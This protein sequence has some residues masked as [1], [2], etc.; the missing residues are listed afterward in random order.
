M[1]DT[2]RRIRA[3]CSV[4][5][6]GYSSGPGGTAEDTWLYEHAGQESNAA[7]FEGIWRGCSTALM[8]R[9]NYEGFHSV[10]PG[11]TAD[12]A[13]DQRTRAL[14]T[15]LNEVDKA[16]VSTTLTE[17]PWENSRIFR[18]LPTAVDTLRSE[19]GTDVL[20]INSASVIQGLMREDLLD[21]LHLAVVPVVLGGGLRL[22]PD[23]V[24]T[25]WSLESSTTLS[26]G[27]VAVHYR[28]A[29]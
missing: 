12:P 23:G 24:S 22:L 5:I 14:G 11:I 9:T 17:T 1:T 3:Q 25:S 18:D 27:A 2:T 29:R 4:S 19:D 20:V 16:V 15:W 28:R 10:W 21:D 6:D 7:H 13:T 8:G 26:H